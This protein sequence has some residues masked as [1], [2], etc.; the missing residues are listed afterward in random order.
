MMIK[1]WTQQLDSFS[2]MKVDSFICFLLDLA[3]DLILYIG[4]DTRYVKI[5]A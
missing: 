5:H 3:G 2:G 4:V 1:E